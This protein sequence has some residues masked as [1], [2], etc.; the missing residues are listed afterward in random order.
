VLGNIAPQREAEQ[1][2]LREIEG[3]EE[4]KRALRHRSHVVG[5]FPTGEAHPRV[6]EGDHRA[7]S[8]KAV[9]QGRVPIVHRAT[10]VLEQDQWGPRWVAETP[11][12]KAD[13]TGI[14]KACGSGLGTL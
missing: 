3:V 11:I 5:H 13:F 14:H 6:I 1:I 4:V 12:G 8:G 10:K 2:D 9:E 7:I